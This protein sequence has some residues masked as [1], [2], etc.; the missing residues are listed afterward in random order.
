MFSS[1]LKLEQTAAVLYQFIAVQGRTKQNLFL[2]LLLFNTVDSKTK[3]N[4]C[5][6]VAGAL[7]WW[8]GLRTAAT[9]HGLSTGS[10]QVL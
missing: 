10:G 7:F 3:Q 8:N 2:L 1:F 9:R 6:A 5:A 4:C